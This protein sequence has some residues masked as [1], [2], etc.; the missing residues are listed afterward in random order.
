M[1]LSMTWKT[2]DGIG[3][4][5][6]HELAHRLVIGNGI[7]PPE[8]NDFIESRANYYMHRHIYLFLYEVFVDILG[9]KIAREEIERESKGRISS[10]AK[11]WTWAMAKDYDQRQK[12]FEQIK[13]RYGVRTAALG[14]K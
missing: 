13:K 1:E 8:G 3:C 6:I 14:N 12:A 5:L 9:E 7:D 2:D 4:T 10:Y 11:A